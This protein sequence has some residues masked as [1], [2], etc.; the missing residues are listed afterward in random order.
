MGRLIIMTEEKFERLVA[1]RIAAAREQQQRDYEQELLMKQA[2]LT[3]LQNQI[4]PH[5]LYNT[6]E[7]IRG[8][9]LMEDSPDIAAAAQALSR[10][11]RYS[12]SG[13]S[14]I[15]TL[16]EELE[17]LKNYVAIQSYRFADRFTLQTDL[18]GDGSALDA[19]VPK[20]SLQPVVENAIIHGFSAITSGGIVS[21]SVRRA[22]GNLR[23]TVSDNGCGMDAV[24]LAALR[25]TVAGEEQP[26]RPVS[27]SGRRSGLGLQN[28]DKRIKYRYGAEY[29]L[30]IQS[31]PGCGT[32]V[33]LF[34]PFRL[35]VD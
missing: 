11:F 28:V 22:E 21:V 33:E 13:K 17:N 23:I 14:D 5:F 24:A 32:D 26:D 2:N 4:N 18:G 8:Q 16:R 19:L 12:I 30:S 7:C 20:L 15:V 6:L 10:F 27:A 25:R 34:L 3:A 29:G 35:T 1:E 9:A 31:V